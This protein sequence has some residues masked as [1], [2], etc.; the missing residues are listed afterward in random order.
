MSEPL[1]QTQAGYLLQGL[2]QR[3]S[4]VVPERLHKHIECWM[5]DIEMIMSPKNQG[6][7]RDI[8]YLSYSAVFSFE[9]FPFKQCNPATVMASVM[10]W[11]MDYDEFREKFELPDPTGDVEPEKDDTVVMT[12]ELE[13]IEPLMVVE[14]PE[15]L[16][17]WDGKTWSVA[18]YEIWVAEH[19]DVLAGDN[20]AATVSADDQNQY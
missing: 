15:G 16:I 18:P 14:D 19:I 11:L 20:P 3:I 13:F 10:G 1:D 6:L 4:A 9:R 8:G 7:G 17:Q 5:E 2:N 12:I